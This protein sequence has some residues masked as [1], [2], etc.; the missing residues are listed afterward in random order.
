[1]IGILLHYIRDVAWLKTVYF[2]YK[3]FSFGDAIKFPVIIYRHTDLYCMKGDIHITCPIQTAL[4]KIGI[5]ETYTLDKKNN[6]TKWKVEGSIIVSGHI[7]IGSGC[8]VRLI[9]QDS[10]L[11]LGHN[12]LFSGG[13]SIICNKEISIGDDC[14]ISWDV[15][16]MDT[17][18]HFILNQKGSVI[19][20]PT[21]IKIGK[22]IW[23]GCRCTILKGI[24]IADNNVIAADS[25]ITHSI[26]E[27]N[28]II[29][30]KGDM[31]R[32]IKNNIQWK[33]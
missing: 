4:I 12:I 26:E 28:S 27:S 33:R 32:V 29:G 8:C 14:L 6:R 7:T 15:L 17:D 31:L 30:G 9:G 23:I 10:I 2:N 21:P 16:I 13:S 11:H 22:N 5:P 20:P 24:N 3:Y 19:N 25:T 18:F 1:M